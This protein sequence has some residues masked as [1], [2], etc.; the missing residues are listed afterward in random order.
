MMPLEKPHSAEPGVAVIS[1]DGARLGTVKETS[2]SFFKID[3]PMHRDF[4]L[5]E[6]LVK[7]RDESGL[8]LDIPRNAVAEH[9][10]DEPGLE[11]TEDPFERI[12]GNAVLTEAEMLDQRAQMERELAQQSRSLPPHEPSPTEIR[13]PRAY[14]RIPADHT[15]FG[16]LAGGYV[17]NAPVHDRI[18]AELQPHPA[19][20]ARVIVASLAVA[21]GLAFLT[22]LMMRRRRAQHAERARDR[23]IGAAH[24]VADRAHGASHALAGK[25]H[26]ASHR[27][28]DRTARKTHDTAHG[29]AH[30][31]SDR[32]HDTSHMLAGKAHE[33]SHRIADR[34]ARKTHDAA[35]ALPPRRELPHIAARRAASFAGRVQKALERAA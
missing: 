18:D 2:G 9:R 19:G 32:A 4:W 13:G 23:A 31:V 30:I 24:V 12:A 17:P 25:A 35:D 6:R 5:S 16:D 1:S 26:E 15:G 29:A 10:L 7:A 28:A 20:H 22:F 34:T 14:E 11:P 27:I 8:L 3:A 21:A 33:A